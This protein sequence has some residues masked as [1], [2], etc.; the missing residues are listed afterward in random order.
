MTF[1]DDHKQEV[2]QAASN[3]AESE[4]VSFIFADQKN[5]EKIKVGLKEQSMI[6]FSA[7]SNARHPGWKESAGSS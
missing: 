5:K 4:H 3:L 6:L 7:L 1:R 2:H